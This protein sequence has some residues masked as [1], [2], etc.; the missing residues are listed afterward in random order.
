MGSSTAIGQ[1]YVMSGT[2][3]TGGT[4]ELVTLTSL[5]PVTDN[6]DRY[7]RLRVSAN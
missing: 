5:V 2:P 4:T 7:Y 6:V 3:Q 1:H